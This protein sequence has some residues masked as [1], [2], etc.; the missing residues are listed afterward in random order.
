VWRGGM[1]R[2]SRSN[3]KGVREGSAEEHAEHCRCQ[4]WKAEMGFGGLRR[5]QH[6]QCTI[7]TSVLDALLP[8]LSLPSPTRTIK[9]SWF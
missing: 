7:Q 1:G 8:L 6:M 4:K 2:G 3:G 9:A 5:V